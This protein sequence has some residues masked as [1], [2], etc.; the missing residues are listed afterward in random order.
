MATKKES[1]SKQGFL[2]YHEDILLLA[3]AM[4]P[5]QLGRL[6]LALNAFSM[7]GERPELDADIAGVFALISAKIKKQEAQY[8][9][10]TQ[11]R[12]AA[13]E[14]RWKKND[15]EVPKD[16][17]SY[18]DIRDDT[19]VYDRM[20][21]YNPVSENAEIDTEAYGAIQ[22][23]TET[24]TET[25]YP[26]LQYNNNN[27]TC[28]REEDPFS[29]QSQI[30]GMQSDLGCSDQDRKT[31][32]RCCRQYPPDQVRRAVNYALGDGAKATVIDV[33]RILR[34]WARKDEAG[35]A[36]DW[37]VQGGGT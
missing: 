3:G 11:Q 24:E 22:T 1:S 20:V 10:T 4:T 30:D 6:V 33:V 25:V 17:T 18:E 28:A 35:D 34:T 8:E 32:E 36:F 9:K 23:E 2:L 19:K 13:I 14:A 26:L 7:T 12:K 29:L 5:D 16:G 27:Y 37:A 21:S 31:L 15:A